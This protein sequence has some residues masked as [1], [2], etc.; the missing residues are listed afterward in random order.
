MR[1]GGVVDEALDGDRQP[2]GVAGMVHWLTSKTASI[3][4]Q[5][6]HINVLG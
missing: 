4:T 3:H 5:L 6:A 1:S 2:K